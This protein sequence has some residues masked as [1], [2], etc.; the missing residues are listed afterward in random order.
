MTSKALN[1]TKVVK[2]IES[3]RKFAVIT[4]E[5]IKDEALY[6]N[7]VAEMTFTDESLNKK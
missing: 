2:M 6:R 3:T 1:A 4:D 7:H 5:I